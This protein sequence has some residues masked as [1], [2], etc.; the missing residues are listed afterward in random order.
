VVGADQPLPW[1]EDQV[2][3]LPE[4][5]DWVYWV[6]GLDG[7][8]LAEVSS[9]V[10][11][12]ENNDLTIGA[13]RALDE[14]AKA[15]G[16]TWGAGV[17]FPAEQDH[18]ARAGVLVRTFKDRGDLDAAYKKFVKESGKLPKLPGM[19]ISTYDTG[20][21]EVDLG[22][23]VEQVLDTVDQ[24]SGEL[25]HRWRYTFFPEVKDEVVVLEFESIYSHLVD[26]VE[27]EITDLIERAYYRVEENV[28]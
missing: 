3:Q 14:D 8:G 7:S 20:E 27:A 9:R 6:V 26:A 23:F 5:E 15:D 28:Q 19:T 11:G 1:E 4:R 16:T 2:F 25:V 10:P 12:G 21:G 24:S 18:H 22:R 13:I 17:W